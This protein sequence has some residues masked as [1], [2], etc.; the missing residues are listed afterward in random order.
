MNNKNVADFHRPAI[1]DFLDSLG[2]MSLIDLASM[3]EQFPKENMPGKC[4]VDEKK[5][6]Y[7]L[8]AELP[9]ME[10]NDIHV[11]LDGDILSVNAEHFEST[12]DSSE[13]SEFF[14]GF[15]SSFSQSFR[16]PDDVE[17]D[18][19]RVRYKNGLLV[20]LM[21]RQKNHKNKPK[22]ITVS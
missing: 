18:G 19:I 7:I 2:N 6:K 16:L 9:G 20:V 4:R 13:D 5:D 15:S 14:S 22:K 12:E 21:K 1:G 3:A 10:K 17:Q 11:F 8:R